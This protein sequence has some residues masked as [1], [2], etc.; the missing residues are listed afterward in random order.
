[1]TPTLTAQSVKEIFHDGPAK[2][3][4]QWDDYGRA[5]SLW[6]PVPEFRPEFH[7]RQVNDHQ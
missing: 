7:S 1:M 4:D 6:G 2:P 3:R 5:A